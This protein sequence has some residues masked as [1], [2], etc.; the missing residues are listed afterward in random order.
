MGIE[1]RPCEDREKRAV[2]E[3]RGDRQGENSAADIS[4]QTSGL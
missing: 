1:R 4:T 2:Y 3:P